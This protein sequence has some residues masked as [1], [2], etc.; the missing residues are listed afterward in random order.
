MK[1]FTKTK[2]GGPDVL[3]LEEVEKPSLKEGHLLVKVYANS[4]NPADWHILR[5][6]PFF[7]RF[8]FGLFNPKDKILGADF[9]GVVEAVGKNVSGFKVGDRVFGETLQ[10]GA[11][12]EYVLA[13][14]A[15]CGHMPAGT[16]FDV[17][18]AVPIAGV[19]ALQA[20][21][22][23]G[24][25]RK[26]ESVLVNGSS[27]GVG[28]FAVQIAKAYGAEVTAV[29]SNRNI[30]FVTSLGADKVLAYDRENIHQ[31]IGNYDLIIDTNGNLT[32]NDYK[33]LGKR[34]VMVG[35]TTIGHMISVLLKRAFSKFPLAQFTAEANTK[36]LNTL[37]SL[38]Q[39]G[40]IQ[41]HIFKTYPY[42]DIPQAIGYIECMR[43]KG[44]VVMVWVGEI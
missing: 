37:A 40:K 20:I 35:F 2:Y 33:R 25:L 16:G 9:A 15:V 30:D 13:P 22:T 21:V 7:A 42:Q 34:G 31:H 5:G 23:H 24:K 12:A 43:T 1:A 6:K 27:G 10:G 28:H 11:F 14:A 32:F 8:S 3:R 29:C 39:E 26:G 38:I 4:A 41:P 36:D 18:A 17:M 19:T 44:K